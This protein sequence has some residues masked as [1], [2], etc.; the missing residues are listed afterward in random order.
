MGGASLA[1]DVRSAQADQ[2]VEQPM[3]SQGA[4]HDHVWVCAL[5]HLGRRIKRKRR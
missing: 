2:T 3:Q 5:H 1:S 4:I